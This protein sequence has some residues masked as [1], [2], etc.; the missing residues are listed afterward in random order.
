V[1]RGQRRTHALAFRALA[2]FFVLALGWALARRAT[3]AR[4]D[5]VTLGRVSASGAAP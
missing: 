5:D 4:T 2:V 3:V 1:T